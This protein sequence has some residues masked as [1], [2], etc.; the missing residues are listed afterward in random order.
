MTEAASG[1]VRPES[2]PANTTLI[3]SPSDNLPPSDPNSPLQLLVIVRKFKQSPKDPK[4]G[5][6]EEEKRLV[7]SRDRVEK[8]TYNEASEY[9]KD[10]SGFKTYGAPGK[11]KAT[12]MQAGLDED[13]KPSYIMEEDWG[14]LIRHAS[15]LYMDFQRTRE[16]FYSLPTEDQN[17]S[18]KRWGHV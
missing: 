9:I 10:R 14:F 11:L 18:R 5:R 16:W 15:A 1:D 6:L 12:F 17:E 7:F 3:T 2:N 13:V 4:L 8:M